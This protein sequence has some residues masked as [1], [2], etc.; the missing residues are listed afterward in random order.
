MGNPAAPHLAPVQAWQVDGLTFSPC[1]K[2]LEAWHTAPEDS[3]LI[4][5]LTPSTLMLGTRVTSV[6]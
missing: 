6:P 5:K 4:A 2:G 1:P 3:S